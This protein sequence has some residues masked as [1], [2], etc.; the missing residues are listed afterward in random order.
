MHA[1]G[2]KNI[3]R[4]NKERKGKRY[5]IFGTLCYIKREAWSS[6]KGGFF[7][8]GHMTGRGAGIKECCKKLGEETDRKSLIGLT[9]GGGGRRDGN[10]RSISAQ[11]TTVFQTPHRMKPKKEV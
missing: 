1:S 4:R 5:N 11:G 10:A 8:E 2:V 7:I 6:E 9:A 3:F